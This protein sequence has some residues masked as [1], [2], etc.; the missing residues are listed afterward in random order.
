MS[1]QPLMVPV[2]AQDL[3]ADTPVPYDVYTAHGAL[4]LARGQTPPDEEQLPLL[5]AY[6][7]QL[8]RPDMAPPPDAVTRA[9]ALERA[10]AQPVR[11]PPQSRVPVTEAQALIADDARLVRELLVRMLRDEGLTNVETVDNGRRAVSHFFR[12]RPHLVFLDIDMPLLDGLTALRQ[13]KDWSPD[14]FVCMVSGNST[15]L[16]VQEAKALGVDGFLVKPLNPLNLQRVLALY[17]N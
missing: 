15:L 8:L 3:Q 13:I 11:F 5:H 7:W 16:N 1:S 6:G 12:Y 9:E 2:A 14:T 4:L 10:P 17:R